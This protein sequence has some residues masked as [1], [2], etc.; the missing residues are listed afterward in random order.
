MAGGEVPG[1]TPAMLCQTQLA[2]VH[3]CSELFPLGL[4]ANGAVLS[5]DAEDFVFRHKE[6][7]VMTG[8]PH[9]LRLGAC[10]L[11][12]ASLVGSLFFALT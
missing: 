4:K 6:D 7:R 1:W 5:L 3:P 11:S 2:L 8:R 10:L 12:M 9:G